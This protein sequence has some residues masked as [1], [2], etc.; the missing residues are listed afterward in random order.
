MTLGQF[1]EQG[2]LIPRLRGDRQED[3]LRELAERLE[4]S[5][6]L[7]DPSGFIEAVLKREGDAP[8]F[9]GNG[10][11]IP[12]V[13]EAGSHQLSFAAGLSRDGVPWGPNI[14]TVVC[15]FAVPS[16]DDGSYLWVIASLGKFIFDKKAFS[17]FRDAKHPEDMLDVLNKVEV[18]G[19]GPCA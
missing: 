17:V 18:R 11:A 19:A 1:T 16:R 4:V 8:T 7:V 6:R 10:L 14:A 5:G 9:I 12:H 3:V 15:L 13:R 2:L